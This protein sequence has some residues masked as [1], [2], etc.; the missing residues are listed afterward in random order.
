MCRATTVLIPKENGKDLPEISDN[1][2]EGLTIIPVS[3]VSEVMKHA[4]VR[5]PE[6][7]EWDQ[8]AE[9][10]AA[11]ARRVDSG[12]G[13]TAHWF[14]TQKNRTA[15]LDDFKGGIFL[16]LLQGVLESQAY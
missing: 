5:Q 12:D 3:H 8:A 13:A 16:E 11:L 15:A 1:V 14:S 9:D 2:K 10:P 4:L 6:A 7:I